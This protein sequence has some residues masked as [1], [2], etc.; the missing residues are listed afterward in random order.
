MQNEIE[1]Q[2]KIHL[3]TEIFIAKGTRKRLQTL[4]FLVWSFLTKDNR[5]CQSFPLSEKLPNNPDPSRPT[6]GSITLPPGWS[7]GGLPST[8]CPF[9]SEFTSPFSLDP[10]PIVHVQEIGSSLAACT[11]PCYNKHIINIVFLKEKKST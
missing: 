7:T 6:S 10:H 2:A 4:G 1:W 9:Y 5:L 11:I 8:S 3:G